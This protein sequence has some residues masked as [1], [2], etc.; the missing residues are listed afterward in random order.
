MT[1]AKVAVSL[2]KEV[3]RLARR[4]VASGR[5]KSLSAF[6][7]EAAA[8][9]LRRDALAD[10]LAAMDAEHGPP[11]RADRTWARRVLGR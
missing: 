4:E 10:V 8:E 5:A 6:L 2:P 3:L 1:T 7:G 11:S 9:K